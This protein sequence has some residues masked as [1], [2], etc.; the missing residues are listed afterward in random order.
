M[1]NSVLFCVFI[2]LGHECKGGEG[3]EVSI[4][5]GDLAFE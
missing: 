4:G 3:A 1:Y 2:Y 5:V